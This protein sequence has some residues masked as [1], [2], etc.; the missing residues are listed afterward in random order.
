[1]C[2]WFYPC[3][4]WRCYLRQSF[5]WKFVIIKNSNNQ[6]CQKYNN[7]YSAYSCKSS[8]FYFYHNLCGLELFTKFTN[9]SNLPRT[10]N[11]HCCLSC[12]FKVISSVQDYYFLPLSLPPPKPI[13][14]FRAFWS[15]SMKSSAASLSL[16]EADF[17]KA[18][19]ST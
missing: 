1:M 16:A 12:V 19:T 17:P 5:F 15:R 18:M 14:Y 8:S 13:R 4:F 9:Y 3:C 6:Y 2:L 10:T 11:L 7:K